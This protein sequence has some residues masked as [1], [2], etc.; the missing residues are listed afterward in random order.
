MT[1]SKSRTV[2]I[3]ALLLGVLALI[4]CSDVRDVFS[5]RKDPPDEFQVVARAPLALH[6]ACISWPEAPGRRA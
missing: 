4:G 3:G 1:F 2:K 6:G 5:A